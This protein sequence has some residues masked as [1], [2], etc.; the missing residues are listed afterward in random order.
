MLLFSAILIGVVGTIFI[1]AYIR[2]ESKYAVR[3]PVRNDDN[4]VYHRYE[5]YRR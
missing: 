3:V 1:E 2:K 4:H 5:N